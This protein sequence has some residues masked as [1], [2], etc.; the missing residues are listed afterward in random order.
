MISLAENSAK[1]RSSLPA[2]VARNLSHVAAAGEDKKT[3]KHLAKLL[4]LVRITS[5]CVCM[6]V[7][8]GGGGKKEKKKK[9]SR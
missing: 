9:K 7:W 4:T 1:D 3:K 6:C 5:P 8:G 2:F